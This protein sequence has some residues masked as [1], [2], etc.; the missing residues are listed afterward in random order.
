MENCS[1][2]S[3]LSDFTWRIPPRTLRTSRNSVSGATARS[4]SYQRPAWLSSPAGPFSGVG[5]GNSV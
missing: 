5:K 3:S 2:V 1:R 4:Q